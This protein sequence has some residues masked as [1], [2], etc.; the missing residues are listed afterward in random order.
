V[1]TDGASSNPYVGPRPFEPTESDRR[2]FYGRD[3]E[4]DEIV[5][6][7]VS[8][9]LVLVYAQSGAGKTSL[10]NAAVAPALE[11]KRFTVLPLARV[12]G[13]IPDDL[14]V[15]AIRNLYSFCALLSLQ[16]DADPEALATTSMSDALFGAPDAP[17]RETPRAVVFDQL[18]EVFTFEKVFELYPKRWQEQQEGFFREI[19][20]MLADDPLLRVVF[21]I[22]KE[23]LAELN[24]FA[25]L[26]PESLQTQFRLD[27]LDAPAALLAVTCPLEG[28]GR[29]YAAGV[30]EDLVEKLVTE[31]VEVAPGQTVDVVGRFAEPVQLQLVCS[32]L[33]RGLPPGTTEITN[34]HLRA[35]GDVS[36]VLGQFYD[37]TVGAAAAA[38]RTS[39]GKLRKQIEDDFITSVGTRGTVYRTREWEALGS[40]IV[41]L[42]DRRLIRGEFRA[43]TQWYEL[44]H[45]RL[46]EP[47]QRSNRAYF[48]AQ[49]ARR[50]RRLKA[51]LPVVGLIAIVLLPVY[52]FAF[53]SSGAPAARSASAAALSSA[54]QRLS[55]SQR[56][57]VLPATLVNGFA[58]PEHQEIRAIAAVRSSAFDGLAVGLDERSAAIWSSHGSGWQRE[59]EHFGRGWFTGITKIGKTVVVVGREG[60]DKPGSAAQDATVWA[61]AGGGWRHVCAKSSGCG[62]TQAVSTFGQTMWSVTT[63]HGRSGGRVVAVG[64]DSTQ[65]PLGKVHFDGAVW[66]SGDGRRWHRVVLGPAFA[67]PGD[68]EIRAVIPVDGTLVAA[69]RNRLDA[70][71]W[72]S[73]DGGEHW[74]PISSKTFH[75][76]DRQ[77]EILGL[78]AKG[79]RVVAVGFQASK[80]GNLA[81][82]AVWLSIN[83][84]RTW[85]RQRSLVFRTRGGKGAG[86]PAAA[87]EARSSSARTASCFMQRGQQMTDV[88]ATPF[89]F[90]AVGLDHPSGP[91]AGSVAAMWTSLD[92]T[93]WTPVSNPS[94][95]GA[96]SREMNSSA[97]FGSLVVAAGDRPSPSAPDNTDEQDAAIWE[98]LPFT[99]G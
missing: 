41:T 62:E 17:A 60:P 39:E 71:V 42:E 87:G 54:Q 52:Y 46:I 80:K 31:P 97:L 94:L 45:D 7:V 69:G 30:A 18:E 53:R 36:R 88:T 44:T 2:R 96:G 67:G 20:R 91:A 43:G 61:F 64:Y 55:L 33:W 11:A 84:G 34:Q 6:L 32:R 8:H 3:R 76:P 38:A 65:D 35:F 22:R 78:A 70:A 40:A 83:S 82:A 4:I 19:A 99:P 14:D 27:P 93:E 21:V 5:S 72:T 51:A 63:W 86:C 16:P 68:Q 56:L 25:R 48:A 90:V 24:R 57:A 79:Q 50:M 59:P 77:L 15:D 92:G 49:T 74:Q 1:A 29:S 85:R 47:I 26:L 81:A 75:A 10:F 37:D 13:A 58:G 73:S 66:L 9:A 12:R 28:T 89:G 98:E 95:T 23:F